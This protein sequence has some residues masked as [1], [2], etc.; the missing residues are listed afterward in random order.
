[1]K[2]STKQQS[3]GNMK[4]RI[5]FNIIDFLLIAFIIY[6]CIGLYS[7]LTGAGSENE[8]VQPQ[9]QSIEYQ[10]TVSAIREEFQGKA[11]IGDKIWEY[12]TGILLGEVTDVTYSSATTPVLDP[13]S[14]KM[15]EVPLPG[16][17]TLTL[18]IRAEAQIENG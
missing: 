6:A 8:M 14:G 7:A 1:M 16:Y 18:R 11:V 15:T 10:I 3:Q 17:L 13:E 4:R 2:Q 5:P 9:A 12:E